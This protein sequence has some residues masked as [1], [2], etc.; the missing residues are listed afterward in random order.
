MG[1]TGRHESSGIPCFRLADTAAN[2]PRRDNGAGRRARVRRVVVRRRGHE[3]V[4][5][6]APRDT[7]SEPGN[8]DF[9]VSV[10]RSRNREGAAPPPR[11]IT[12][13]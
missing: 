8:Q 4:R 11:G 1:R 7:G 13:V 9:Q 3:R 5:G 12:S 10:R 2:I 6:L